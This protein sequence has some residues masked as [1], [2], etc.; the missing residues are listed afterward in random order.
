MNDNQGHILRRFDTELE[1]LH[2]LILEMGGLVCDQ[3][4]RA[5]AALREGD[6]EA[7][8]R[9]VERD[10]EINAL[11]VRIDDELV[12]LVAKRQ[13][14]ARDLRELM[15]IAKIATD[16]ERCGDQVRKAGRLA[17]SLYGGDTRPLP[18]LLDD[19]YRLAERAR[20]MV[21]GVL[22]AFRSMDL[23]QAILVI[24]K[25]EQI[26]AD[27][28]GAL[29]RLATYVMEDSRNVG[30]SIEVTLVLRALERVGGH[31]KNIAGHLVYL[32]T[33]EDVRHR[34]LD[35]LVALLRQRGA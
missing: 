1:Q 32:V 33:G 19:V 8:A 5:V 18:A 3:I 17:V 25:D 34:D 35:E 7:G 30:H 15:T 13:P 4:D 22:E 28:Q 10:A 9:M 24:Q 6:A 11:D 12:R 27:F 20:T 16:L 29:R 23:E 2:G 14:M 21:D 31:A 26:E